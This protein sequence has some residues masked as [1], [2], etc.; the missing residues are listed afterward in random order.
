MEEAIASSQIEGAVTTR[1]H[2]KEM[3]RKKLSPKN[4]SERMIVNNYYT[5][6]RILEL[7]D[8][9]LTIE[10]LLEVHKLIDRELAVKLQ[11]K[12]FAF[13]KIFKAGH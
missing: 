4:K 9:K 1:K 7:K 12:G 13:R 11:G 6:Q 8:E 2:A 3:L 5:I 10:R